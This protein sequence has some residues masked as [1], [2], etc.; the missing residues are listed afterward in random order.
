MM[1]HNMF[2]RGVVED[3][4]WVV[5]LTPSYLDPL[6]YKK[7][8]LR[9]TSRLYSNWCQLTVFCVTLLLYSG[10][11]HYLQLESGIVPYICL[12]MFCLFSFVLFIFHIIM[13]LRGFLNLNKFEF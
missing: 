7:M 8:G 6:R 2:W 10:C 3:C 12:V 1:G 4:P 13:F 5:P 9:Y 11:N